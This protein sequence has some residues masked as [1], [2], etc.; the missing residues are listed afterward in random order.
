MSRV[1]A[2]VLSA[3]V[4]CA[5]SASARAAD[6]PKDVLEKAITAHGGAELLA[7]NKAGLLKA[8]GKITL[9]GV[10]DVD[11]TQ[12]AAFM[13]P[14][15]FKESVE[16]TIMGKSISILT[17]ANGD[18]IS[19]EAMGQK[20]EVSDAIKDAMKDATH[21]ITVGRLVG[22]ARE[23][24][25]ELNLIGESKVD[26]KPVVG[27]RVSAKGKKDISLFFDAKTNLL[28]KMEYRS[29]DPMTGN[30]FG[31]ERVLKD[32]KKDNDGNMVPQ[33]VTVIR[34]GKKFLDAEVT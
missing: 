26:D 28:V 2:S 1:L 22:P 15:K 7:K 31:E 6:T 27:V 23:K 21:M 33:K 19:I 5:A 25:F 10:G 17:L 4:V 8:K 18:A 20:I 32:Y 13:L 11:F 16:I 34:D 30:E 3:V 14:D 29:S 24:G 9:P 12:E